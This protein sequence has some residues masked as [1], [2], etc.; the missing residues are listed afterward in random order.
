MATVTAMGTAMATRRKPRRSALRLVSHGLSLVRVPFPV[1]AGTIT[2]AMGT[3]MTTRRNSER[4]AFRLLFPGLTLICVSLPVSAQNAPPVSAENLPPISAQNVPP[5]SAQDVA[6][7]SA[8]NVAPYSAQNVPPASAQN[9]APFT[10][11]NV[12]PYSAQKWPPIYSMPW[13]IT[14]M[15]SVHETATD[16]VS[17]A[18]TN[19]SSD[20]ITDINPGLRISGSGGRTK[21]HVDYQLHNLFYAQHSEFNRSRN[22]LNALG[23]IEALDN[24]LFVDA[25]AVI[26]HTPPH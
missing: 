20:W 17:L 10:A 6:P 3:D 5:A 25:S 15:L 24:W 23:T 9:V 22:S 16:N 2:T 12:T 26:A 18:T 1:Y 21:A 4:S 8:P 19:K 14:P 11:P 7:A 13:T